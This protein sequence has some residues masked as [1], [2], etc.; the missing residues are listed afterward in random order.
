MDS[1]YYVLIIVAAV[2]IVIFLAAYAKWRKAPGQPGDPLE[3]IH[4]LIKQGIIYEEEFVEVYFKVVRDE[5]FMANFGTHQEEAKT[6][7]TTMIDESKGHKTL[8]ESVMNGLK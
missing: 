6:L 1:L 4:E 2:S 8:L 7:L 5:G 3:R